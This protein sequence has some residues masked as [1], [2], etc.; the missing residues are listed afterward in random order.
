MGKAEAGSAKDIANRAKDKGLKK[1]A[2]WCQMCQKQCRDANGFK[3][4]QT[5]QSHLRMMAVLREDS[6]KVVD[7]F[8]EEFLAEFLDN[9]KRRHGVKRVSANNVYQEIIQDK[10]H[11]HMNA[12]RWETLTDFIK[13]LGR[14]GKCIVEEDERGWWVQFIDRDEAKI[15]RAE[16]VKERLRK[17]REDEE[18][19][20]R[21]LEK[22]I[23]EAARANAGGDLDAKSTVLKREEGAEKIVIAVKGAGGVGRKRKLGDAP[24]EIGNEIGDSIDQDPPPPLIHRGSKQARPM[25]TLD[26]MMEDDRRVAAAEASRMEK[27]AQEQRRAKMLKGKRKKNWVRDGVIVKI[28]NRDLAGGKFYKRKG[29]IRSVVEKFGAEVEVIDGGGE[30]AVFDQDDLETVVGKVGDRVVVVNGPGRGEEA[31]LL[32]IKVEDYCA[33]L[34]ILETGDVID[35]VEYE[36]FCKKA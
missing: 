19:A 22:Q 4:H 25:T 20:K 18:R 26:Q 1:L 5:S 34:R 3:Q 9:L 30:A 11:V 23:R 7:E 36:D 12:T 8:S 35:R 33:K 6:R 10:G 31:E 14:E 15:R 27:L 32:E 29:R 13:Y 24:G 28:M 16:A 2:Y 17:E 21:K